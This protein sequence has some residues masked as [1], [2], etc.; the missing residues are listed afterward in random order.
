MA[1]PRRLA[2]AA[3]VV[4]LAIAGGGCGRADRVER[5][6][7]DGF[8]GPVVLISF[9]ALR[10]DALQRPESVTPRLDRF[11]AEASWSGRAI[12]SAG[13]STGSLASVMTGVPP[14][15][16]GVSHP[17]HPWLR[18]DVPTL[19]EELAAAGFATRAWYSSPWS[20]V[21]FGLERGFEAARPLHR[22]AAERVL[23]TLPDGAS[24]TWIDLP[25]PGPSVATAAAGLEEET[26]A[27]R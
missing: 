4:A 13:W 9:S 3:V 5:R 7:D 18:R 24:L 22:R 6:V 15:M 20:G 8:R 27:A 14:S 2:A 16:T 25:L 26:A 21:G 1:R 23:A 17:A 10:A 12:A 19:A 11:F